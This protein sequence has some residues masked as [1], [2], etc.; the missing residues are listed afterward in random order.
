MTIYFPIGNILLSLGAAATYCN[1][2]R[3]EACDVLAICRRHRNQRD[4]MN[5]SRNKET[6]E[7]AETS[8]WV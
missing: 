3:L 2:T 6:H 4:R 8:T 1:G 5:P 7:D